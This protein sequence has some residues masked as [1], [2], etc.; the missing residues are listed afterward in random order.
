MPGPSLGVNVLDGAF[1][2]CLCGS[3]LCTNVL[4]SQLSGLP[5]LVT[6]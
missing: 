3:V 4:L 1:V 2:A 6:A 5:L